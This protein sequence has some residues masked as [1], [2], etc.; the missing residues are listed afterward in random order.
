LIRLG[1]RRIGFVTG[2]M[3]LGCAVERLAGYHAALAGYGIAPDPTLVYSGD[4][5][6]PSGYDGG[7]ALLALPEP[8]TA[9]FAS[10]DEMAFG[11]MA[12]ARDRSLRLPDDVS[13]V[14]FDDIPQAATSYPPLTTVRQPLEEMGRVATR[15][16]VELIAQPQLQVARVALPTALVV[17]ES[18]QAPAR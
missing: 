17:R 16:L 12:A 1:H 3:D 14:G 13:I 18:C 7:L 6:Q 2:A 9:I 5:H 8:P 11:V 10:N 4:F 15:R